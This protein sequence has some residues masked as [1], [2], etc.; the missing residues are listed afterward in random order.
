MTPKI[1]NKGK[2]IVFLFTGMLFLISSMKLSSQQ[3]YDYHSISSP[4]ASK[5]IEADYFPLDYYTGRANINIPLYT[6]ESKGLQMPVSLSYNSGG[7]RVND[8][9][10]WVGQNWN[11]NVGGVITRTVNNL[12][13]EIDY[14][15]TVS[16]FDYI[17]GSNSLPLTEANINTY[18]ELEAMATHNSYWKFETVPDIFSFN[19]LGYSGKFFMGLDGTWKVISDHN[20][21]VELDVSDPNNKLDAPYKPTTSSGFNKTL[22]GF[23]LIDGLGNKYTFGFKE[24]A[25]EYTVPFFNQANEFLTAN[26][27]YLTKVESVNGDEI[28]DLEYQRGYH[29]ANLNISDFSLQSA[30]KI[31]NVNPGGSDF[32]DYK[33]ENHKK[34]KGNLILPSYLKEI[35]TFY[36]EVISFN[37]EASDQMTYDKY[38]SYVQHYDTP[39]QTYPYFNEFPYNEN[40]YPPDPTT[41]NIML[42]LKWKKLSSI[43]VQRNGNDFRNVSFSYNDE[44]DQRLFLQEVAI[45]KSENAAASSTGSLRYKFDYIGESTSTELPP[46][47]SK[48][49]DH[50][51]YAISS[52]YD[53]DWLDHYESREPEFESAKIGTLEKITYPTG[54]YT[55]FEYELNNFAYVVS[56]DRQSIIYESGLTCGLRVKKMDLIDDP[57]TMSVSSSKEIFY[58]KNYSPGSTS[59]NSSGVLSFK[60]KYYWL[61]YLEPTDEFPNGGFQ[62][63]VFSNNNLMPLGNLFESHIGYDE[64]TEVF[65]NGSYITYK[66]DTH[67]TIKDE[68]P[69]ESFILEYSPY[70]R[71]TD[72]SFLRGKLIDRSVYKSN[73]GV[74]ERETYTR[75]ASIRNGQNNSY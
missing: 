57:S 21:K 61:D 7:V 31:D 27:W 15:N 32:V 58:T 63:T 40:A 49:I 12:P 65:S 22:Y 23:I 18:S 69:I 70:S 54:G 62:K 42:Q 20:I 16:Y 9:N 75:R 14:G 17:L 68:L 73:G 3:A 11:L 55:K 43:N 48:K 1:N 47:L 39:T 66:Y 50:L 71:F 59:G 26:S 29:I 41:Y 37:T 52:D 53:D 24:N 36:N 35:T 19:F 30:C 33:E 4:T 5:I 46:F 10:G 13:D 72:K 28:F 67:R 25:V 2:E 51:G 60:P 56:T 34:A 8:P 64:V 38:S 45:K 44:T 74:I 6:I